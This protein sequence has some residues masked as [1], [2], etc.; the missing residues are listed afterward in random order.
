MI[1]LSPRGAEQY[2]LL[3]LV[4]C[5]LPLYAVALLLAASFQLPAQPLAGLVDASLADAFSRRL[6]HLTVLSGFLAG[7]LM[8]ASPSPSATALKRIRRTWTALVMLSLA[9]TPLHAGA[10]TELALALVLLLLARQA[11]HKEDAVYPRVLRLGIALYAVGALAS[12]AATGEL[13]AA[14]IAVFQPLVGFGMAGLSVVFWL[15]RR[16]SRVDAAWTRDGLQIVALLV[17]LAGSLISL[18]R[19]GLP[20]LIATA[21]ALLV[22]LCYIILAGHCARAIGERNENATLAPHYIA[23]ATLL[24]LIGGGFVGALS[25]QPG[26]AASAASSDIGLMQLGLAGWAALAV[27]LAW[28]NDSASALRGENRRV[29]GYVPFWLLSF[30]VGL[31]AVMEACRGVARLYLRLSLNPEQGALLDLLAPLTVLRLICLLAVAA[32]LWIYA[33]GFWLRRM[34]IRVVE[35]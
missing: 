13:T 25:L 12:L 34:R 17:F 19:L 4:V 8:M 22:P 7:G 28:V 30:G 26:F 3:T 24:W 1:Q 21:G 15:M 18:G 2:R 9:A 32:S 23:L 16:F 10:A 20:P 33:L 27:V 31:A 6:L 5:L 14:A 11:S 29:T 35:A